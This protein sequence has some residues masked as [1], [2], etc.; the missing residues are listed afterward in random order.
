MRY[1]TNNGMS[2]FVNVDTKRKLAEKS[3]NKEQVMDADQALILRYVDDLTLI[4][5]TIRET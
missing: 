5:P 3:L 1:R 2:N 4:K